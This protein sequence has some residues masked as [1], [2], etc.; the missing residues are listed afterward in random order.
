MHN[1]GL[2]N[3]HWHGHKQSQTQTKHTFLTMIDAAQCIHGQAQE[4]IYDLF[5]NV[6][7]WGRARV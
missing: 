3:S 7:F 5:K 1:A 6:N 4:N 2:E